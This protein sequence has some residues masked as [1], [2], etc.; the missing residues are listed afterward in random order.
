MIQKQKSTAGR[1]LKKFKFWLLSVIFLLVL[2]TGFFC[3]WEY[4]SV[5]KDLTFRNFIIKKGESLSSVAQR[6]ES[7]RFIKNALAFKIWVRLKGYSRKIQAG[8]YQLSGSM[9]LGRITLSLT[10]G[11]AD[12]WLTFPEGWRREEYALR[13]SANLSEFSVQDFINLTKESEG[14]LF[15]DTYLISQEASPT[16]AKNILVKN[17]T[18]KTEN[19]NL[20]EPNLILA[21]IIEREARNQED[22]LI[23][24][25]IL[26]K[27]LKKD[28][29]LQADATIQYA[30]GKE[31]NWWPQ[32]SKHDLEIKSSFN[33][34]KNIGLPPTPI[35][36]PG[37]I[38]MQAV[39]NPT[40]TDY[41]FYISDSLGQ[42]HYAKT[43]E[44]QSQNIAKYL[45]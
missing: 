17:F 8:N 29:P 5:N 21:S 44:E 3:S 42:I 40:T 15:P 12:L 45:E 14:Q 35:C 2:A 39:L 19:L 11:S 28:W 7:E 9:D 1:F 6:L 41:W 37:L 34:Y 25:G 16:E 24:A 20:T 13:L 26:Q 30:L 22:K 4:C 27:R 10:R 31:G 36:N 43:I 32:L 33:T 38:S 18:Q 23:V